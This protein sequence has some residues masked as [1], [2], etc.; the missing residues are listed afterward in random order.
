MDTIRKPSRTDDA[1]KQLKRMILQA[2]LPPGFQA[3]EVEFALKLGMSRTPVH[4]ALIR[5]ESEGLVQITARRGA[6]ILPIQ[7]HDMA[8]IYSILSTLEPQAAA[9]IAARKLNS[10]ELA[11]LADETSKMEHAL[12]RSDLDAWAA[13]DDKFHRLLL[14][15]HGNQRLI[16]FVT[17]LYDQAH[18]ARMVTLRLREKPVQSTAEHRLILQHMADGDTRATRKVFKTHRQRAAKEL[19]GVLETYNLKHL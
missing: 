7:A 11:P 4:E 2:E 12:K 9:E 17:S 8:E 14:D 19:L 10:D 13:A 15:L 16:G 6:R 3:M 1:Y 5:L 18:R